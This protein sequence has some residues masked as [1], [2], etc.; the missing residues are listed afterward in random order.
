LSFFTA[1]FAG[2][3]TWW[4]ENDQPIDCHTTAKMVTKDILPT[5]MKLVTDI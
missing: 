4:L 2:I 3:A 5:Y 1:G